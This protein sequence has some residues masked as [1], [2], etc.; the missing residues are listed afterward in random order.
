MSKNNVNSSPAGNSDDFNC[1]GKGICPRAPGRSGPW[2]IYPAAGQCDYGTDDNEWIAFDRGGDV[3][4]DEDHA[5]V[6]SEPQPRG[7]AKYTAAP[8]GSRA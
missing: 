2:P 8:G 4:F 5:Y 1:W 6:G 7:N 3:A